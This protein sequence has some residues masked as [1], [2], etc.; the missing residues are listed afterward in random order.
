MASSLYHINCILLEKFVNPCPYEAK[1]PFI[2]QNNK[3]YLYSMH[4]VILGYRLMNSEIFK[5]ELEQE[6]VKS[7]R[8]RSE[9]S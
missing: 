4:V 5:N 2:F 1:Y 9:R 7:Y 3:I 6:G 8:S